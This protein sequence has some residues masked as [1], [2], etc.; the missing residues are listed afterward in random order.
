MSR[1]ELAHREEEQGTLTYEV[2]TNE[3]SDRTNVWLTCAK[4]IFATQLPKMPREYIVRLLFDRKHY[5]MVLLKEQKVVGG[6]CFRPNAVQ[7]FA[8]IAFCA[9]DANEQVRG[10]GTRLMNHVKEYAKQCGLT[11]FLTYVGWRGASGGERE[12]VIGAAGKKAQ[13]DSTCGAGL[14]G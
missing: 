12:D 6:L 10:Y 13:P 11:H 9:I 3:G 14:C 7:R 4:H 1:D 2:I 5:T 8:E